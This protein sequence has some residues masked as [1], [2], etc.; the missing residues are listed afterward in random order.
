[1]EVGKVMIKMFNSAPLKILSNEVMKTKLNMKL[2]E[3]NLKSK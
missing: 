1:M 2:Y 3:L